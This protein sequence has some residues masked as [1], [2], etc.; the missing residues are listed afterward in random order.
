MPSSEKE[1]P[2]LAFDIDDFDSKEQDEINRIK[3]FLEAAEVI[4]AVARQSKFMPGGKLITPRTIFAR[5]PKDSNCSL[6][7]SSDTIKNVYSKKWNVLSKVDP[8]C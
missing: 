7:C 3:W 1:E 5:R 4:K 8:V 6:N 2:E